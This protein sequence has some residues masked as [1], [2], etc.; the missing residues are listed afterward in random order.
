VD[1]RKAEVSVVVVEAEAKPRRERRV[2][3]AT[4]E[5]ILQIQKAVPDALGEAVLAV[6]A[7]LQLDQVA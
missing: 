6:A 3:D 7:L 5:R 4:D 2:A 1:Q